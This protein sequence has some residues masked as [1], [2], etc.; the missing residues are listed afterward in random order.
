MQ[1]HLLPF[2]FINANVPIMSQALFK[3]LGR[4]W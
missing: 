2:N 1:F 3:A 4:V